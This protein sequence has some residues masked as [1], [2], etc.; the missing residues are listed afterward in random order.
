MRKKDSSDFRPV[1]KSKT[2]GNSLKNWRPKQK[3]STALTGSKLVSHYPA[4]IV[5][6]KPATW[7]RVIASQEYGTPQA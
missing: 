6:P 3:Q 2:F 4:R 7:S 1:N 5:R